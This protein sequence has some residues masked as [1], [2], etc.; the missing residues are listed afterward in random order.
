M[1]VVRG[2]LAEVRVI[3]MSLMILT[4]LLGGLFAVGP[5]VKWDVMGLVLLNAFCFLYTAHLNDTYWDLR[6][7]E[8]EPNRKL[9]AVRVNDTAYLPRWGFGPEIP[10]APILPKS[11]YLAGMGVFIVLG[12]AVMLYLS[13]I[14]GWFYSVL[15]T[16]GLFLALTYA[17]G[18]DKIQGLGDTYWE[19]GVLFALFCGYYSQK[20]TIDP[21]II[22]T[23]IPL[24]IALISVKA[25]DSLPD[26]IVDDKINKQTLTVFLY[27]KGV[28]LSN[29]RHICFIPAYVAFILL[30]TQVPPPL[31][32]A[33]A[34]TLCLIA[35]TH[36]AL[37]RDTAGRWSIV[38]FS[39]SIL[40][41]ICYTILTILGIIGT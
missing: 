35:L 11:Y 1:S 8:Y 20:L 33:V 41:F 18:V 38:A 27:R 3:P 34:I 36:I 26:T 15:A 30:L 22:Q 31:T 23:A 4:C 12:T 25:L 16:V 17:A 40:F 19:I 37:R 24:F 5:F 13:N 14:L 6:K 7:G 29:I 10:N 21:F 9:H 2:F 28:S 32:P 39:F